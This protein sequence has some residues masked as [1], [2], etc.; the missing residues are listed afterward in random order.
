MSEDNAKREKE[1]EKSKVPAL[2]VICSHVQRSLA[3]VYDTEEKTT[4]TELNG[5]P[6]SK[7]PNLQA[8]ESLFRKKVESS[9]V[10]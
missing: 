8:L 4:D 1:E 2:G 6:R 9:R 7:G 10:G 3:W 5:S